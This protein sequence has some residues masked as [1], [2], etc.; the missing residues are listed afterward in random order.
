LRPTSTPLNRSLS[1]PAASPT[2]RMHIHDGVWRCGEFL[3]TA[4]IQRRHRQPVFT[5]CSCNI[6]TH[7][8]SANQFRV[9]SVKV[10]T[11]AR[12]TTGSSKSRHLRPNRSHSVLRGAKTSKLLTTPGGGANGPQSMA[13]PLH[14]EQV[15]MHGVRL[16]SSGSPLHGSCR[17]T[18][19]GERKF[20]T[21]AL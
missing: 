18:L 8:Y 4:T 17:E 1:R 19:S 6:S 16:K 20:H 12:E 5:L 14:Q 13:R 21:V 7:R 15:R 3:P 9:R 2:N 11:T 10:Q